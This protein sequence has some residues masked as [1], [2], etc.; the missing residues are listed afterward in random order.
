M[1]WTTWEDFL[2]EWGLQKECWGEM[3]FHG[4]DQCVYVWA[5]NQALISLAQWILKLI[6]VSLEYVLLE[7]LLLINNMLNCWYFDVF[8]Y[9]MFYIKHKLFYITILCFI[10]N[11]K[12]ISFILFYKLYYFTNNLAKDNLHFILISCSTKPK[13]YFKNI[14]FL[15]LLRK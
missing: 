9:F 3:D 15:N 10:L 11:I 7:I 14:H 6:I 8:Y 12:Y 4:S 2:M 5:T 13:D 1:E